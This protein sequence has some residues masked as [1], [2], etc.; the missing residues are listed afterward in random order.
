MLQVKS[1]T[2][3]NGQILI[4]GKVVSKNIDCKIFLKFLDFK[5]LGT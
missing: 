2:L 3:V 4:L 5:M 1:K